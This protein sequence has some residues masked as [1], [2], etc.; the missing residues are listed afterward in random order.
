MAVYTYQCPKC[1][2]P[3]QWSGSGLHCGSCGID[4]KEENMR[5]LTESMEQD[6]RESHFNWESGTAQAYWSEEEK[7]Q[8]SE[9]SCPSCSAVIVASASAAAAKCPYCGNNLLMSEHFSGS[10]RPDAVIPFSLDREQ[11]EAKLRVHFRRKRL[12]PADFIKACRVEDVTGLYVPYFLFDASA[13]ARGTYRATRVRTRRRGDWEE[14]HTDHF[15][16]EREGGMN[17]TS[18]PVDACTR[19]DNVLTES[20]EPFDYSA[21]RSFDPGYFAGYQADCRDQQASECYPRANERITES[22]RRALRDTVIGYA[23]VSEDRTQVFVDQANVRYALMP[24]W[25]LTV[26]YGDQAFPFAVN[27]QTG[28]LA[29]ELPVDTGKYVLSVLGYAVIVELI[30]TFIL[31][32]FL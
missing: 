24:V 25:L 21:E 1:G 9:Y 18:V 14:I 7:Q 31:Y 22:A 8:V 12:L 23:T 26:R 20:I 17:F 11:A 5:D 4:Y 16:V 2:A 28:K 29:G 6:K 19:I 15:Y 30:L 10:L 13:D 32:F 3:L 27:G